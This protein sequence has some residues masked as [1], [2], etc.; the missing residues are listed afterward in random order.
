MSLVL[1]KQ[2]RS[3]IRNVIALLERPEQQL[4]YLPTTWLTSVRTFLG[5]IHGTLQVPD[6]LAELPSK[7]RTAD[8]YLMS[9]LLDLPKVPNSDLCAFNRVRLF[10]GVTTLAEITSADGQH[11]T[12]EA[13]RGDRTRHSPLLWPYQTEPGP[14][15]FSAWRRLLT[16]A[17][18]TK[19]RSPRAYTT[20]KSLQLRVPL[21]SWTAD[22]QWLQSKWSDFYCYSTHLLYRQDPSEP[23]KFFTHRRWQRSRTR[24]PQF[25]TDPDDT[26]SILPPT[27]IPVDASTQPTFITFAPITRLQYTGTTRA[28]R[29]PPV[30][31]S[32]NISRRFLCGTKHSSNT[33]TSATPSWRMLSTS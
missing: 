8:Q 13:W 16:K 24:R 5:V 7:A 19:D 11:L 33:W 17:F 1:F 15:S 23:H 32:P 29:V 20:D 30:L 9:A 6:A 31:P 26:R 12:Q 14:T 21:G 18:L 4:S 22:S 28:P 2:S 27:A 3:F 10:L 25:L